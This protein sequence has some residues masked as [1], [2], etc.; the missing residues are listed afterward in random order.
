MSTNYT[1]TNGDNLWKIVRNEYKDV[2]TNGE[3]QTLVN[4]I[5]KSNNIT[6]PNL[7]HVGDELTLPSY[8]SIF[9]TDKASDK[10]ETTA[11]TTN[12]TA[13]AG[14][15]IYD[16]YIDWQ[17]ESINDVVEGKTPSDFKFGSSKNWKS[18]VT[19]LAKA[20]FDAFDLDKDGAITKNEYLSGTKTNYNKLYKNVGQTYN[21]EKNTFYTKQ[22][23]ALDADGDG[24]LSQ[25]ELSAYYGALD[26]KDGSKDGKIK[27]DSVTGADF[28]KDDYKSA[29]DKN[30]SI[31]Q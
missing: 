26:T 2:N 3:I 27:L 9:D 29:F 15:S 8:G 19:E 12:K 24:K 16:E 30:I 21:K 28:T 25:N 11:N 4:E 23:D 7:I 10:K 5:A 6:N 1:V 20:N 18:K 17:E 22:F 14:T 31:F 13:E